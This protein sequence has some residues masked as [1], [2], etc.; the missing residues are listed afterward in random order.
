MLK[1]Y[2]DTLVGILFAGDLGL[3]ALSWLAAYWIRFQTVFEAPLGVPGLRPYLPPLLLILPLFAWLLRSRGLYGTR[4]LASLASEVAAIWEVSLVGVVV[5][6]AVTFFLRSYDYSRGVVFLFTGICAGSLTGFRLSIRGILRELRRRGRNLRHVL[7]IGSGRLAE[8]VIERIH[9]RAEVGL[10][11]TG[12]L[13]DDRSMRH[14]R[15]APVV[16]GYGDVKPALARDP[17]DQVIV[18]LPRTDVDQLEKILRELEDETVSVSLVPDLFS[19]MTLASRGEDFDGIPMIG[20]RETPLVGW[21]AV[22]KRLVDVAVAGLVLLATS[23]LAAAIALAIRLTSGS[24]VLYVQERM[25]LDG[26]VFR[27]LKFRTM[28]PEAEEESGAVWARADDPRRT[29]LGAWLRRSNLDELPQLWNVFRGDMSLVGPRPE[30]P[31]LIAS[32]RHE[33]P[34]YMLRHK[35]KAGLTGWAQVHGWRGDTSLHERIEHD[36]YYIQNWSMGLDL[37]ILLMTL[38]RGFRNAY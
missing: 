35:V 16:G 17:A 18:A 38:W 8:E 1:R 13:S 28:R 29:R 11:I 6:V 26:R 31:E 32:F 37:R 30:R 23:P 2:G 14:V 33:I 36:L 3:V 7:V 12:V 24:P 34:G 19:F 22:Q 15:G 9:H 5:L 4:R 10:R 20:L 25:G 27:M 21:S